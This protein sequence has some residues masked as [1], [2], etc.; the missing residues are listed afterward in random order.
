MRANILLCLHFVEGSGMP[1]DSF[2]NVCTASEVLFESTEI[3]LPKINDLQ[4]LQ[5]Y[6][7]YSPN[8][9]GRVCFLFVDR[10]V[11]NTLISGHS[12]TKLHAEAFSRPTSTVV[13]LK[14]STILH[15]ATIGGF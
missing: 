13:R 3:V 6:C 2:T 12:N 1:S 10:R 8:P 4:C 15:I 7:R 11:G 5:P 9:S 14:Y